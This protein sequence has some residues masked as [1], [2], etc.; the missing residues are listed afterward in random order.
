MG[1]KKS[2]QHVA[3]SMGNMVS[4]AA[5]TQMGPEIE[6]I[7]M[8]H[9]RQLG[10]KLAEQQV[11]TFQTLFTRLVVL[12]TVII[13]KMGIT[14]EELS[15]RVSALEDEK[16]GFVILGEMTEVG[17]LVRVGVKTRTKDQT[18]WQGESLLKV[19]ELGTGNTLGKEIEDQLIG[20]KVGESRIVE[21]GKDKGM[22]GEITMN[23]ISRQELT[24]PEVA[25]EPATQG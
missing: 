24:Q 12:E 14:Q 15:T 3:Q 2:Q 11:N 19:Y 25:N 13:E 18:A 1:K 9:V 21:F 4:R 16:E 6:K 8:H 10:S 17:D 7:V 20:M 23:R 22:V 5:L